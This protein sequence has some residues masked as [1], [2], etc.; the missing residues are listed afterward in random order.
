MNSPEMHGDDPLLSEV[1]Q[2]LEVV[3]N[4]EL[5]EHAQRYEN[6]HAKLNEALSSIEGM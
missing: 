2:E 5:S 6:L 3:D 1:K 4:S